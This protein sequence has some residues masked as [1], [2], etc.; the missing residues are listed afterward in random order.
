MKKIIISVLML[1]VGSISAQKSIEEKEKQAVY[2][3]NKVKS[4]TTSEAKPTIDQTGKVVPGHY[5]KISKNSLDNFGNTVEEI[6]Y[7]ARGTVDSWLKYEFDKYGNATKYLVYNTD[8]TI[9]NKIKIKNEYDNANRLKVS[10]FLNGDSALLSYIVNTYNE[11]G[12]LV[13]DEIFTNQ[14]IVDSYSKYEYDQKG[15]TSKKE[16]YDYNKGVGSVSYTS[17]ESY[18]Y[19]SAGQLIERTI[20]VYSVPNQVYV[21]KYDAK[22]LIIA[23]SVYDGRNKPTSYEKVVYEFRQ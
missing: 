10:K 3:K 14:N 7:N 2:V 12:Q 13:K 11:Q 1:S 9:N 16:N 22:G 5:T 8:G 19:N 4:F 20:S 15:R 17:D 21:C 18:K 6:A 23:T